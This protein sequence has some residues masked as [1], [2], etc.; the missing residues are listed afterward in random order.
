MRKEE[1]EGGEEK[2]RRGEEERRGGGGRGGRK[3][4]E[5][6]GERMGISRALGKT[7]RREENQKGKAWL[8]VMQLLHGGAL[9]GLKWPHKK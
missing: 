7:G 8:L 1:G 5:R 9:W 6:G 3:R 4:K 2:G